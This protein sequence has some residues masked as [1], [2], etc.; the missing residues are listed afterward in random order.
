MASGLAYGISAGTAVLA[1]L[2]I[3]AAGVL[4]QRAASRRP[5]GERLSI[6]LMR[7]LA[8]DRVWLAGIGL[9]GLSYGFQAVALTFGPLALVQPLIVSELLFAVPVSVRL[10]RLR[11]RTR[12][13]ATVG[14]IVAGLAIG[15]VAA[16][17]RKGHPLQPFTTWL[18]AL[19]AAAVISGV[20]LFLTRVLDGPPRATAFAFAGAV[21]MAMQSALYDATIAL[22]RE[23]HWLLFAHWEP[24]ALVV[25]SVVG[26]FLIQNAF[27]AGPLAAS[28][29]VIDATLPLVAI[30]LGVWLFGEHVRTTALG[31][32]GAAL[33]VVLLVT[34]IVLLDRSPV[35]RKE[36]RIE[37]EEQEETERA[38][39]E[40]EESEQE[41]GG[42]P[43]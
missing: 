24:Y 42:V 13:W 12:D 19:A 27:Q 20:A 15:I 5:S 3:A 43:G 35:V 28:T 31:L 37:Q 16:D 2:C 10:R 9:A 41:A 39:S 29:P 32:G 1:G 8:T 30:A 22:L 34:G 7:R 33:G 23:D 26:M 36:Q 38:E 4:Q 14:T 21:L 40:Q 11:L 25:A 6:R 17:P 18:P